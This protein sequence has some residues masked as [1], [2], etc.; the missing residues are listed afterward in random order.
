MHAEDILWAENLDSRQNVLKLRIMTPLPIGNDWKRKRE[1]ENW[2]SLRPV[3]ALSTGFYVAWLQYHRLVFEIPINK[4]FP[5]RRGWDGYWGVCLKG[6][7]TDNNGDGGFFFL[8]EIMDYKVV[9]LTLNTI[10]VTQFKSWRQRKNGSNP[11]ATG[12]LC[13]AFIMFA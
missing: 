12:K 7:L 11:P 13:Y 2:K 10:T 8:L 9:K 1:R 4:S 6:F 5:K 3:E